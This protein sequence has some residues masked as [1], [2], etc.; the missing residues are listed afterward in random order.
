MLTTPNGSATP[1]T[2]LNGDVAFF[3]ALDR[4]KEAAEHSLFGSEF[5]WEVFELGCGIADG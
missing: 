2:N 5:G 4:A 3:T 1:M